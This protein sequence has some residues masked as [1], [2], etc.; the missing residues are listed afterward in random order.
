MG[1]I[2]SKAALED[3]NKESS[4]TRLS[5]SKI[6]SDLKI[7]RSNLSSLSR[8]EEVVGG[9]EKVEIAEGKVF[10]IDKQLSGAYREARIEKKKRERLEHGV[11]DD[12]VIRRVPKAAEGE[13]VAA[14][15]P[16]W[17]AAA[18]AEAIEGW[19]PR[20][21]DTFEKLE[22]VCICSSVDFMVGVCA[23]FCVKNRIC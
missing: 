2:C 11:P 20:R 9:K 10:P 19:V 21:A 3:N 12:Q 14:G 17:L 18:A 15:W 7:S 23:Y 1:C 8:K 4:I 6:T 13:Q 16:S 5:S 22:K